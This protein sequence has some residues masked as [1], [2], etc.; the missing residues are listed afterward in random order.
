MSLSVFSPKVRFDNSNLC[1]NGDL[2]SKY[3]WNRD[4]SMCTFS[5]LS[6]PRDNLLRF[7][8]IS[9]GLPLP[10]AGAGLESWNRWVKYGGRK[11]CALT[12][13]PGG[14]LCTYQARLWSRSLRRPRC[15]PRS[16]SSCP[17]LLLLCR[18]GPSRRFRSI[19]GCCGINSR[20]R[21]QSH[22]FPPSLRTYSHSPCF[23]CWERW[24]LHLRQCFRTH[25]RP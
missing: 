13:C 12:I 23:G 5:L 17:W 25:K 14:R 9:H 16:S 4:R 2:T 15:S 10:L 6:C 22:D 1:R 3:E 18:S 8:I 20:N 21:L 19:G 7:C 24:E 11:D